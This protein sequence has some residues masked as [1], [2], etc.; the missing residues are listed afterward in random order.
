MKKL[1][2]SSSVSLNK[3]IACTVSAAALML[4]VSSAATVGLH[5]QENYCGAP[6]YSGYPVTL[7]AFGIETNGWENL[8]EM[9][10]GYGSCGLT[11][12]PYGYTFT[13]L[14]DTTTSTNGLNPLPSGSLGVTW[15]GPTANFDPF[16]GYAGS[17][18]HYSGGGP[19]SNPTT[20][21]QQI[22]A[23]FMRDGINFGPP[24]GNNNDQPG[25]YVDVT[26]LKSLFPSGFVVELM[27]SSD[28]M[29]TLTNALVIDVTDSITNTVSYPSTPPVSNAGD[30]PW[31]RGTGG[32]LSTGSAAL[33]TDHAYI[34]SVQ[35]AHVAGEYN[36]AGTISG[37]ILTDQPVVTMSPQTIPIAGPG[38]TITLSAYAI[39]LPPLSF[40]WSKGGTAIP[41]AT[42]LSL[43]ISNVNLSSAGDYS[44]SAANTFGTAQ[45]KISTLKVDTITQ[46]SASDL[47]YDSNPANAQNNGVDMGATFEASDS[48]G[49]ITRNG[50]MSFVGAETNGITVADK[51]SLDASTGTVTFWMR[52]AINNNAGNGASIFCRSTGTAGSDFVIY[53]GDGAPGNLDVQGPTGS[54]SF[55][56]SGVVG[57]DRWHFVALAFDQSASGGAALYLDGKQDTTNANGASWSW[58][59]GQPL[60]I[61]Y[62]SDS[63]WTAFNGLLNDVRYYSTNLTA[64]QISTIFT[65]GGVTDATDLQMEYSFTGAPAS[66]YVLTWLETSAVLQTA[67]SLSGPWTDVKGAASPYTIVP[68]ETQQFF[69]YRYVSQTILSNPYLM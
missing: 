43:V 62:S 16:Y 21:E 17:P 48:D 59:S 39:G 47:V 28:S 58:T 56:S 42:N 3:K 5:F 63:T 15:W 38:D 23:T 33:N 25:Y 57:D 32:G 51:P 37:F 8:L 1:R 12:P 30:A 55:I 9:D 54:F 67:P 27:A 68:T 52:A 61:G 14:I 13:E 44:L 11:A 10:D 26:G 35:P 64:S 40:Q 53:Q 69:R 41:G 20:G 49:T 2:C 66:G 36:H 31:V 34:T 29:E 60:E 7:T 18:P 4:G 19:L 6:A 50:V 22:Y 24:G 45:S 65:S 46:T